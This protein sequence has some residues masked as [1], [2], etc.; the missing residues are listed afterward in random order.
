MKPKPTEEGEEAADDEDAP[1]I[2]NTD[3]VPDSII[4]LDASNEF[5]KDFIK[6]NLKEEDV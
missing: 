5:L 1:K 3:L 4:I 6:E 2:L